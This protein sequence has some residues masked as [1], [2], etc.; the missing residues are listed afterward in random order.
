VT[1]FAHDDSEGA[2]HDSDDKP[3]PPAPE[4][5]PVSDYETLLANWMAEVAVSYPMSTTAYDG[6]MYMVQNY[7]DDTY[8]RVGVELLSTY[9]ELNV[10]LEVQI[11]AS[12]GSSLLVTSPSDYAS[13]TKTEYF[14]WGDYYN[15]VCNV[16]AGSNYNCGFLVQLEDYSDSI[17]AE[18]DYNNYWWS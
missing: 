18:W 8:T 3:E 17:D 12:S 6:S 16:R 4:P 7:V 14:F 2:S 13:C 9:N 5:E 15:C 11:V 1:W 10:D